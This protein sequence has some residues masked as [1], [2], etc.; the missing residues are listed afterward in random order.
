MATIRERL[1]EAENAYHDV[2]I[3]KAPTSVR[4]QNGEEIR[5]SQAN[6]TA[7]LAYIASLQALLNPGTGSTLG[8]M[9]FRF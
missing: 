3:G 1:L 6:P 8:P 5:Y 4:D 9:Q 2:Q 7:L